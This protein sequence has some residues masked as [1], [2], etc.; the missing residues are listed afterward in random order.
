VI[1]GEAGGNG[2]AKKNEVTISGGTVRDS[3]DSGV[4]VFGGKA[5]TGSAIEN[6]VTI[7][8]NATVNSHVDGGYTTA[9]TA[10]MKLPLTEVT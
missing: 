3:N 8:K 7:N 9:G 4:H 2:T 6:K 10:I 5:S 1:G